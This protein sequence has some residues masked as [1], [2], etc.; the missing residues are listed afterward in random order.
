MT[1]AAP[2]RA[3]AWQQNEIARCGC[4]GGAVDLAHAVLKRAVAD[5]G[6]HPG[7][8]KVL[9]TET[10]GETMERCSEDCLAGCEYLLLLWLVF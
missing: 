5:P 1:R 7:A 2:P 4:G 6:M 3:P 8:G 10:V 9:Q